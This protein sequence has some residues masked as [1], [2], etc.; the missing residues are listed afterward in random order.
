MIHVDFD[1]FE[2]FIFDH[3]DS[4]GVEKFAQVA[5]LLA[6]DAVSIL[7]ALESL[8]KY[9]LDVPESLDAVTHAEAEIAEPFVVECHGPVFGEELY[10]IRD[11]ALLES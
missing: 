7:G 9:G 8:F 2:R 3:L 5:E 1:K 11:D 4:L 10:D 6:C